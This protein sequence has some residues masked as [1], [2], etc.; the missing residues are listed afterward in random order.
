MQ[1]GGACFR[2][3]KVK[4]GTKIFDGNLS[5]WHTLPTNQEYLLRTGFNCPALHAVFRNQSN[6]LIEK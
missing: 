2:R 5:Q 6:E 3:M 1:P 4:F